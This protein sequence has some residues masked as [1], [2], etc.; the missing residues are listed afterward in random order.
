M[1]TRLYYS[2]NLS[3]PLLNGAENQGGTLF[4]KSVCSIA[5]CSA[6]YGNM[7]YNLQFGHR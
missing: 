6:W 4:G 5:F 7:F 1:D 3:Q 2:I